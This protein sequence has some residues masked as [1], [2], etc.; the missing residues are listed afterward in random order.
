MCVHRSSMKDCASS[1]MC[2]MVEIFML[3]E[4]IVGHCSVVYCNVDR[5]GGAEIMGK[6]RTDFNYLGSYS[7]NILSYN[8]RT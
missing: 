8:H 3:S 1:N 4:S 2:S 6:D 5:G 7:E